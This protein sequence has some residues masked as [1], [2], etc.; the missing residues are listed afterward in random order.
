MSENMLKIRLSEKDFRNVQTKIKRAETD[1]F[2]QGLLFS[3]TSSTK[4]G[5]LCTFSAFADDT[6]LYV[7]LILTFKAQVGAAI[8]VDAA[9]VDLEGKESLPQVFH[10]Q[11][12]KRQRKFSCLLY[13]S[14][15]EHQHQKEG[16]FFS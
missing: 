6:R 9:D 10:L 16:R 3:Y 2:L 15:A 1:P 4:E 11:D 14:D 8:C 12:S 5:Y 7:L 13:V